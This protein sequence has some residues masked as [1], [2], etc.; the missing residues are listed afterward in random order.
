MTPNDVT[1]FWMQAG[2]QRWFNKDSAFDGQLKVRFGKA[3]AEARNG[4]FDDWGDT[5][6]GALGLVILLDQIPRN[7][8]RGSPL[9]F[10][11]DARALRLAK[12]WIG[13]GYHWKLPAPDATW[14]LMPLE[15]SEA[16]DDQWRCCSLFQTMGLSDKLHWA[17]VHLDIITRFGRFPHRNPVLGRH[18]TPE[19]LAFL[20]AGGF[21]G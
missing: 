5:P 13:R 4:A 14:F 20:K 3:W 16:I 19:E 2:E 6:E 1:S 7:I 17:K 9:A 11:T 8:H 15:H 12:H 21:A 10:A 18:S